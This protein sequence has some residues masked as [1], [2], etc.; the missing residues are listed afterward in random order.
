MICG[1]FS[2]ITFKIGDVE[3]NIGRHNWP[4]WV[5]K[6]GLVYEFAELGRLKVA[7]KGGNGAGVPILVKVT[8][9]G[10]P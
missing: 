9:I 3:R 7:I 10:L 1:I 4:I 2:N 6:K 8:L 5:M